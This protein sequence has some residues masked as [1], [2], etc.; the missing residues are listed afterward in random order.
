MV[1]ETV[2]EKEIADWKLKH[3]P[4]HC[5]KEVGGEDDDIEKN[6]PA[7]L[8]LRYITH[9]SLPNAPSALT[10]NVMIGVPMHILS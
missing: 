10:L 9:R 3:T 8:S 5:E 1:Q 7:H 4:Q 2:T 6:N